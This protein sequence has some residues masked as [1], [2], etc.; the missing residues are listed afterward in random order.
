MPTSS[1][2][3]AGLLPFVS[4]VS[5]PSTE[6]TGGDG[7][8]KLKSLDGADDPICVLTVALAEC[9]SPC[10]GR[11]SSSC[12]APAPQ[13][14]PTQQPSSFSYGVNSLYH[15]AARPDFVHAY[16]PA[17]PARRNPSPGPKR[18]EKGNVIKPP[19]AWATDRR[20]TVHTLHHLVSGG[21]TEIHGESQCKRC[22]ERRLI[23]YDLV[24]KFAAV[25]GFFCANQHLMHDRAPSK[26]MHP[27][28]PDCEACGQR[29][30]M[31]PILAEKKREMNWLFM[32]LG[33]TLGYCTHRQLKYFCKYNGNHRTG[34]K[35]RLLY[36]TYRSLC[37]QL[38]PSLRF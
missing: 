26:W 23:R 13:H 9:S 30:C 3:P 7:K 19:F 8:L 21:I 20:A 29:N 16:S 37:K 15:A 33:Q 17:K 14:A 24:K 31:R 5:L 22:E 2:S 32:L 36:L 34:A 6:E 27:T 18:P 35:N 4:C 38:D 12:L 11:S 28:F 10:P 1:S 25:A